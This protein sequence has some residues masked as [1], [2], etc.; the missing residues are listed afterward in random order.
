MEGNDKLKN[1]PVCNWGIQRSVCAWQ[2]AHAPY[3]IN[4]E[5]ELELKLRVLAVQ[6]RPILITI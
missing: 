3:Q 2:P 1:S 4:A 5:L 6:P